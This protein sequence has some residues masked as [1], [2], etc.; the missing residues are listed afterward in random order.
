MTR[1]LTRLAAIWLVVPILACSPV[2]EAAQRET[3]LKKLATEAVGAVDSQRLDKL[4]EQVSRVEKKV[5]GLAQR[6]ESGAVV[7]HAPAV[8]NEETQDVEPAVE[9]GTPA[10]QEVVEAVEETPFELTIDPPTEKTTVVLWHAYR[11]AEKEALEKSLQEFTAR[12]PTI[13]VDPQEVPFSALR[14]KIVVTVPRG[15]G[16]DLFVFAHNVVGDWVLKGDILVPL[17]K[18]LEEFDDY[19]TLK[20]FIPDTVLALVY[21]GTVYGL[22]LAFKSHALFYNKKLVLT[23]P[24]TVEEMVKMAQEAQKKYSTEEDTVYGLVYDAGLFYNHALWAHAYGARVMDDKGNP[25]LATPAMASSLELVRSFAQKYQILP[26]FDDAM[27]TFLFNSNQVAFV[28]KGPWFLGEIEDGVDYG[29]AVLPEVEP[30]KPGMP[31]LGSDG[32]F[33][34]NCAKDK[35]VAFQVM[36][37]LV[38]KE[39][40]TTRFVDGKQLVANRWIYD[41]EQLNAQ[42]DPTM[43][44]FRRQ[45]ESAV[46]MSSRPEMQA[47]WTPTNN[48]IKKVVYG[49]VEPMTALKE[50]QSKVES[51]VSKMGNR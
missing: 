45:A 4:E 33:L 29:V 49:D 14:D 42:G 50:A 16:P 11:G 13:L 7:A 12:F 39:C 28:I 2:E 32:V 35:D 9:E 21:E 48:A 30:G 18:Y 22:P 27:A 23:P 19:E 51:D 40:A 3:Q 5:D 38:S 26:A 47:V 41:D 43:E 34:S 37:W 24:R 31:F 8:A 36:R 6:I 25:D 15:N 20:R 44:V 46:L 10:T 1:W 17:G